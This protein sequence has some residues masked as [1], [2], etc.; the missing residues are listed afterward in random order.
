M[1]S[2]SSKSVIVFNGEIY[3]FKKLREELKD[4]GFSFNTQSDTE[5]ILAGYEAW[6]HEVVNKIDGMFAFALWDKLK[7]E[8]FLARD[9]FGKKPL[10]F[11]RSGGSF[12]F[13]SELKALEQFP[14]FKKEID[15][16]SLA[17]YLIYDFVPSPH[18]IFKNVSKLEGG[19][20]LIVSKDSFKAEKYFDPAFDYQRPP[21]R[22]KITFNQAQKIFL[23]LFE[24]AVK[25]RLVSDVPFGVFLSGGIDSSSVAAIAQKI[26]GQ[27]IKTFSIGFCE[28]DFDESIYAREVAKKIGSEHY[29]KIFSAK[30]ALDLIDKIPQIADEPLADASIL[31]TRLLSSFARENVKVA[32]GGDGG[33]E[34]LLGYPTFS[35][36]KIFQM[37]RFLPKD[38]I[39]K[40]IKY[41]TQILQVDEGYMSLDFKLRQ[42]AK[43]LENEIY[44]HSGKRHQAWL[45]SFDINETQKILDPEICKNVAWENIFEN[46]LMPQLNENNFRY[47]SRL[48]LKRY[49]QDE[50][51]VKVDRASMSVGLETRSPFLDTYLAMFLLNLPTEYKIKGFNGKYLLKHA[52]KNFLP[53]SVILRKKKGFGVPLDRWINNELR[54]KINDILTSNDFI[55]QG[56]FDRKS[57]TKMLDNHHAKKINN[58]KK[59]WNLFVLALWFKNLDK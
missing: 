40:T 8:L 9:R 34:L 35:A 43:G 2:R 11:L 24:E 38:L 55:G 32:L 17:K 57:V 30:D 16:N 44:R 26:A 25:K 4:C 23:N 31:P 51:M 52:M 28:K 54:D 19:H 5:V 1:V 22:Q 53:K 3:N 48:Y 50:V 41:L 7:K 12:I 58:R 18:S 13:G 29:E 36:E 59:I 45:G 39:K 21:D 56:L 33:D 20:Y 6:G 47:L 46:V 42:F 10:Y 49:L 27:K 15:Q 14:G 37:M